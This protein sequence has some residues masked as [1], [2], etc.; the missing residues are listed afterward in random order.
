MCAKS[1][2]VAVVTAATPFVA[3]VRLGT[4]TGFIYTFTRGEL[5]LSIC[6][7]Y[8]LKGADLQMLGSIPD[9][10]HQRKRCAWTFS[11]RPSARRLVNIDDPP[12][13]MSGSGIPVTGIIPMFIPML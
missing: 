13:L 9:C 5:A 3:F 12:A 2:G 7:S 8:R 11:T 10:D 6:A 4:S 1:F